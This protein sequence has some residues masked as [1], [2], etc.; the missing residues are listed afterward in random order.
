MNQE[1]RFL[2]DVWLRA[3]N[4]PEPVQIDCGSNSKAVQFR[5]ALYN[6]AKP[7]KDED[8]RKAK[9]NPLEHQAVT[10]C[11]ISLHPDKSGQFVVI[12]QKMLNSLLQKV[13]EQLGIEMPGVVQAREMQGSAERMLEAVL[14]PRESGEDLP[15]PYPTAERKPGE[16]VPVLATAKKP[17]YL[18][19]K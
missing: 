15:V 18:G 12:R 10:N 4:H 1:T 13:G 6:A 2:L 9:D 19:D 7:Y 14:R 8:S 5:M 3:F 16:P 17:Y 11:S